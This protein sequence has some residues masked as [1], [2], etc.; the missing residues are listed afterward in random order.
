MLQKCDAAS[1]TWRV[2]APSCFLPV[3]F[4]LKIKFFVLE[5]SG[6]AAVLRRPLVAN[7]STGAT[8]YCIKAAFNMDNTATRYYIPANAV[9]AGLP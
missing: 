6:S 7:V 5:Q 3:L 9:P 4:L 8:A 2:Q 1:E